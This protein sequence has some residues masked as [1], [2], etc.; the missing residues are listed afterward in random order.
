MVHE[1]IGFLYHINNVL[2]TLIMQM[3]PT[4]SNFYY[5]SKVL[6]SMQVSIFSWSLFVL[7][8]TVIAHK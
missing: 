4:K 1:S 7:L 6:G 5:R 8:S 2:P 3:K